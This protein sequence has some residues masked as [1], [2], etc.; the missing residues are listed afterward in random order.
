MADVSRAAAAVVAVMV[1]AVV[2]VE[3]E[4]GGVGLRADC[5]R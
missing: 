4:D 5:G 2:G 1:L 3:V